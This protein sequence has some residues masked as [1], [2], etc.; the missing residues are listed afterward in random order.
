MVL[1]I[2]GS[3]IICYLLIVS[4]VLVVVNQTH[5]Q[6]RFSWGSKY[7]IHKKP[8]SPH[9][10]VCSSEIS[11]IVLRRWWRGLVGGATI[12]AGLRTTAEVVTVTPELICH[13]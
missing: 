8:K 3:K 7:N 1:R 12:G 10:P 9:P 11:K 5:E 6:H 4:I 13:M 2:F